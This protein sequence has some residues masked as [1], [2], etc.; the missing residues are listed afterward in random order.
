MDRLQPFD[1]HVCVELRRRER[2]VTKQLLNATEVGSPLEQVCCGGVSQSVR[3]DLR[4]TGIRGDRIVHHTTH[5][6]RIEP[7]TSRAEEQRR[8]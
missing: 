6:T 8:T 3:S 2:S 1:G 4:C 5:G 7:A